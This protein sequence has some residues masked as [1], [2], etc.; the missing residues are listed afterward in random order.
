MEPTEKPNKA[1]DVARLDLDVSQEFIDENKVAATIK[2]YGRKGG[3]HT[4]DE[5]IKRQNEV[6]RLHFEYGYSARKISELMKVNRNTINGDISYWYYK[7]AKHNT[8]FNPESIIVITTERLDIQRTRLREYLD[9]ASTLQEKMAIER[10]ILEIDLKMTHIHQRIN[11]SERRLHD[12]G[13]SYLNEYLKYS[14]KSDRFLPRFV[15]YRVSKTSYDKINKIIKD[16][17]KNLWN[18]KN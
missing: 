5:K 17:E 14:K 4:K 11:D 15:Q 6:Y 16:D 2:E 9:K 10:M 12:F 3:P 1:K 7:I 13:I 18:R 8:I